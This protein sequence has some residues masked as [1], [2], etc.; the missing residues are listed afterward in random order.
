MMEDRIKGL[1][2]KG[3]TNESPVKHQFFGASMYDKLYFVI[4]KIGT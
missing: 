2:P 4:N 3:Y 1:M